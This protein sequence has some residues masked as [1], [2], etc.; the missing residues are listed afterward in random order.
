[1][2][3]ILQLAVLDWININGTLLECNFSSLSTAS[4]SFQHIYRGLFTPFLLT[5]LKGKGET[6]WDWQCLFSVSCCISLICS[7][8]HTKWNLFISNWDGSNDKENKLIQESDS[9]LCCCRG[10]NV[11]LLSQP[12]CENIKLS[13][14]NLGAGQT[15]NNLVTYSILSMPFLHL[16]FLKMLKAFC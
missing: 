3:L 11:H 14:E 16:F 10:Y 9:S 7:I 12:A 15:A 4:V 2:A 5:F 8:K 1:M 13:R 6:N